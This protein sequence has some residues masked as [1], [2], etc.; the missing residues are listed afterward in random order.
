MLEILENIILISLG[1]NFI[2]LAL[3]RL[4]INHIKQDKQ[5]YTFTIQSYMY[6]QKSNIT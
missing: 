2:N 5:Y 1:I 6:S 3:T 4:H